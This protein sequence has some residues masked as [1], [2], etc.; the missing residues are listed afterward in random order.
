[1]RLS[2][3][4]VSLDLPLHSPTLF[5]LK[6]PTLFIIFERRGLKMIIFSNFDTSF[7]TLCTQQTTLHYLLST[8]C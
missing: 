5:A 3:L 2:H 8:S 1:M 6:R 7:S 4:P